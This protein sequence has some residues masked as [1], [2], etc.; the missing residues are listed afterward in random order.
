MEMMVFPNVRKKMSE[1]FTDD[2]VINQNVGL[3]TYLTTKNPE[4]FGDI[5]NERSLN[6]LYHLGHSHDKPVAPLL[7]IMFPGGNLNSEQCSRVASLIYDMYGYNWTRLHEALFAEYNPIN[8]YD[9]IEKMT[10]NE[11]VRTASSN[12]TSNTNNTFEDTRTVSD[13]N[14]RTDDLTQTEI[15]DLTETR[16]P[17]TT[18]KVSPHT[19]VT[20]TPNTTVT[21][22]PNIKTSKNGNDKT[23]NKTY[24]FNSNNAV[25]SGE[26][27]INYNTVTTES[28]DT[29]TV[30]GGTTSTE[31]TGDTTTT[32]S[33]EETTKK[34]GENVTK[35]TGTQSDE[36]KIENGGGTTENEWNASNTTENSKETNN[37]TLTRSGNIGVTTSQ[38]MAESEVQLR[39]NN[40][41]E[42]VFRDIDSVLTLDIYE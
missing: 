28:G 34:S 37:Y 35:N 24:G 10:N 20:E 12:G 25:P 1:Y 4:I 26:S 3:F 31:T 29:T 5:S 30:S 8:N 15:P 27:T 33:G 40:F 23:D 19:T 6:Y 38:M 22:S 7:D 32:V 11:T 42:I 9:M 21:V 13:T 36:R 41:I 39:K 16:T 2:L 17:N 14:K 18:E